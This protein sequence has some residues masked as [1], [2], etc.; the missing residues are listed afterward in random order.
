MNITRL[1]L[2][3]NGL[4]A[5]LQCERC[6]GILYRGAMLRGTARKGPK[7]LIPTQRAP[8]YALRILVL[9]KNACKEFWHKWRIRVKNFAAYGECAGKFLL[10]HQSH[11]TLLYISQE[12]LSIYGEYAERIPQPGCQL[13]ENRKSFFTVYVI[14]AGR[15][16]SL[17]LLQFAQK[18][19]QNNTNTYIRF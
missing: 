9:Q 14:F 6:T 5:S 2:Y 18:Y 19:S 15:I 3:D 4:T 8:K 7:A 10:F 1:L 17:Y 11:Q 16:Y 12:N 13:Q